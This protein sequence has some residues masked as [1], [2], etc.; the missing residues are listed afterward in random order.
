MAVTNPTTEVTELDPAE[1]ERLLRELDLVVDRLDRFE[2]GTDT[3]RER[4]NEL[5]RQLLDGG[6]PRAEVARRTGMSSMAAK[7]AA[8]GRDDRGQPETTEE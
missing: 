8:Y 5:M 2:E 3:A 1:R 7:W 6:M 4:R